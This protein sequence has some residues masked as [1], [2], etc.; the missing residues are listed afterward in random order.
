MMKTKSMIQT[1]LASSVALCMFTACGKKTDAPADVDHSGHD[2]AA[3]EGHDHVTEAHAADAEKKVKAAPHAS[4]G[5]HGG[6]MV[7][8]GAHLAHAEL[9]H[10]TELK[11]FT[12]Y[13]TGPDMKSAIE[14]DAAPVLNLMVDGAPVQLTFES[15]G[16]AFV[17]THDALSG[18]VEGH[19]ALTLAENSYRLPLAHTH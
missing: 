6:K 3:H 2:H 14:F 5:P 8:V 9:L 1:L 11:T 4:K 13:F 12:A 18:E 15:K 19:V 10:D 17:A 16:G 7:E